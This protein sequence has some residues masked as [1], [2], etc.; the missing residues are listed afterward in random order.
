MSERQGQD[1]RVEGVE[2]PSETAA[3]VFVFDVCCVRLHCFA[4]GSHDRLV[5]W[6][7]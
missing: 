3:R 4:E 1:C 5:V 6:A 7:A 2:L